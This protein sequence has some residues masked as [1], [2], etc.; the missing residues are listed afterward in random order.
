MKLESF[1]YRGNFVFSSPLKAQNAENSL[2]AIATPYGDSEVVSLALEK[3]ISEFE[4]RVTDPD[5]TSPYSKLTCLTPTENQ[6]YTCI[7]F[8]NDHLYS[9]YNKSQLDVGCDI[10]I[11]YKKDHTLYFSQIG[12]P[13][14]I[15]NHK[16]NNLP[17][18]SEY[19]ILPSNI[20]NSAF[21]PNHLIGL[22]SSINA[23]V[24]S[25]NIDEESHILITKSN[26][27]PHHLLKSYPS[28][29]ED[30]AKAFVSQDKNQG[31]WLGEVSF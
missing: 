4:T 8:L 9:N 30:I 22:E 5:S 6:I 31:F 29:L 11:L 13:L 19:S 12:W 20:K 2:L 26:S 28:K 10:L 18:S 1:G 15:L 17:I 25:F 24:Q 21:L 16:K 14:V 3:M 7:Q 23:K 27:N